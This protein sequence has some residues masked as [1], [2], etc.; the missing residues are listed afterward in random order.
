MKDRAPNDKD[1]P[2]SAHQSIPWSAHAPIDDAEELLEVTNQ[3]QDPEW[4]D[5]QRIQ[6]WGYEHAFQALASV[7]CKITAN[8][9]YRSLVG[10]ILEI[11]LGAVGAVRGAL[12]LSSASN[13]QPIPAATRSLDGHELEH[14]QSLSRTIVRSAEN[15]LVYSEDAK[16]DPRFADSES[17][18]S[19]NVRSVVCAPVESRGKRLGI[20]YIDHPSKKAFP[21]HARRFVEAFASIAAVALENARLHEDNRQ[22]LVRMRNSLT[23]LESFG[24]IQT[25]S[26][27]MKSVLDRGAAIARFDTPVI[28]LGESGTGKEVLAKAIHQ[29]SPRALGPFVPYNCAAVPTNLMESLF[30]GHVKG[31]FTG[32]LRDSPGLFRQ[33]DRGV[34]FLDEIAE[35]DSSLQ[36]KLL[37]VLEEGHIWPV[38][39]SHQ[40]PVDV[41]IITATSRDLG[42]AVRR[43]EFREDL[44]FRLNVLEI[45]IPP[46]RE[47]VEDIPFLV[48][49]F[50]RKHGGPECPLNISEDALEYLQ[51]LPWR[52]NVRELENLVQRL[53]ILSTT[54]T[55]NLDTVQSLS[56]SSLDVQDAVSD[57]PAPTSK[58]ISER[59]RDAIITALGKTSGNK[60]E[61]ARLLG[62]HRNSLARRMK[63]Y[64]IVHER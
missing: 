27:R 40:V 42:A 34:L 48:G 37:R 57:S 18:R 25:V 14:I 54:T 60:S 33:A 19:K 1:S 13:L 53:L 39:S 36:A 52:G 64:G 62:I 47:R 28:L 24:R 35:L 12:F 49:H 4:S 6:D 17:I 41:R 21:V 23:S 61:A 22:E 43:R 26:S 7:A 45:P 32:A 38:G 29:S 30:F 55:V 11:A 8:L 9:D 58:T 46:L 31:A 5:P 10:E 51:L 2:A 16:T 44:F 59:E 15:A 56:K 3:T 50:L 63:R 20:L